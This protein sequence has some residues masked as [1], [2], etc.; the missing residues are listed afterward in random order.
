M[1]DIIPVLAALLLLAIGVQ[2]GLWYM[3]YTQRA[4]V[5]QSLLRYQVTP[6][7]STP[8]VRSS[9]ESAAHALWETIGSEAYWKT[10]QGQARLMDDVRKNADEVD[11]VLEALNSSSPS[12]S[13]TTTRAVLI[14]LPNSGGDDRNREFRAL[15]LSWLLVISEEPPNLRTDLVVFT[16][17]HGAELAISLGCVTDIRRDLSTPSR[18]VV[19]PYTP[20]EDRSRPLSQPDDP[21]WR[22]STYMNSILSFAEYEGYSYDLALRTDTDVFLMPGFYNWTLPSDVNLLVG[23]GGYTVANSAAHLAYVSK[24]LGLRNKFNHPNVGSTWFGNLELT[25]AAARLSVAIARWLI[26]E[27]YSEFEKCCSQVLGWPHWHWGVVTMYSG[28]VTLNHIAHFARSGD[29][30][31]DLDGQATSSDKVSNIMVK[32]VHCWHSDD[33]FSKFQ[34]W[35]GSYDTLDLTPYLDMSIIKDFALVL[36]VSSVRLTEAEFRSLSSNPPTLGNRT[37]WL[38]VL[39]PH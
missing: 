38:R 29:G 22:Y 10:P 32:H 28:H 27:E 1:P 21:L 6:N 17:G 8:S 7:L 5:A 24:T 36:A 13:P 35:K 20:L 9:N 19:T 31:G 14:C 23:Q 25:R 34:H 26:A 39:P 16:N 2:I 12:M 15:Y 18:C 4:G 33:Q 30:H 11:T 37:T 3:P